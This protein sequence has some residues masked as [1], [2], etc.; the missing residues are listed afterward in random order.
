MRSVD[1]RR[2]FL[3]FFRR[4]DHLVVPPSPLPTD[5]PTLLLTTAG[6]VPFKPYFLGTSTPPHSRLASLQKCVRTVD[7]ENIGRTDRHTTFFEMLGNFSFG[8]YGRGELIPWAYEFL[9]GVLGLDPGRLWA[10]VYL[11]DDEAV[12]AWRGVGLPD[13]R[14][15]RLGAADNFWHTGVPG[16]CGP[17]SEV[18]YDRG[19][20]FGREGGPAVD[21]ERYLEIWGLVFMRDIRGEGEGEDFPIVG[22][23]PRPCIDTGMGLDRMAI[24]LQDVA[25]VHETDLVAPTLDRLAELGAGD[26][27]LDPE[28]RRS[29]RIVVDHVRAGTYLVADGVLPSNEG[30][31][32]VLR[33]LLRRATR[34]ARVLGID[35]PVIADLAG[36]IVDTVG[37]AWPELIEHRSLVGQA[38]RHEEESF[39]RTLRHGA[40]LLDVAIRQ[41]KDRAGEALP[42]S[43]AFELH[44]TYGFPVDLTLELAEEAGLSVDTDGF[45]ALMD[46]QRRRAQEARQSRSGDGSDAYHRLLGRTGRSLFVG[47]DA[48]VA[49]GRVRGLLRD[50]AEVPVAFE[51]QRVEVV[52]DQ[53]PF[54][55]EAGGQVGDTGRVLAS[56]GA[57]GR[58][59]DTRY[60]VDGLHVHVVEMMRGELGAGQEVRSVVDEDRRASLTRSHSATHVLHAVLRQRLGDHARQHGSL[61]APGRLRF[62]FTHFA[63]LDP[64]Q[65]AAIEESVNDR[66]LS[67][68]EVRIWEASREEAQHAGAVALF[69]ETYGSVV[70][71]VDIGDFS[72]ELC[73]GTHVGHGSQAGPVRIV[74]EAS[75]GSGVRRI[76]A[77]SGMDALR[78]ADRERQL[79]EQVA[80]LLGEPR[81]DHVVDRLRGRL[82]ALARAERELADARQRELAA[83]AGR[84]ADGRRESEAR[85]YVAAR[86]SERDVRHGDELQLVAEGVLERGPRDRPGAV[87]LG[88][89]R[90][91]KAQLLLAVNA[92]FADLGVPVRDVLAEAGRT[93]GGGAGGVGR[94]AHAGGRDTRRIDEALAQV[95]RQLEGA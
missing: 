31:G 78:H 62:D 3:D 70:R 79:L 89:V 18:F 72:R 69:G 16:P 6:M 48:L 56:D 4:H 15:Q 64:D 51:G 25:N 1:I 44:D 55:A 35:E 2:S 38:F 40:R 11:D 83:V 14:I 95:A 75:V 12:Q 93:I 53:T 67:D 49:D 63:A 80:Q 28:R 50:G 24:V 86:V 82:E 92:A 36:T 42:G 34:H 81:R 91:G 60:G 73:G 52:L 68:P 58:V 65:L 32:Y 30:S 90:D 7:I 22:A 29:A 27:R 5:D 43:T 94:I 19:P 87:V 77:L 37:P 61:V 17:C 26:V 57:E 9:T 71:V 8:D 76:E 39:G 59:V 33:R 10:T 46:A 20:A 54:Y 41:T 84:L 88:L 21:G 13:D 66:L 47:H 85:W 45:A 23:L 74:G